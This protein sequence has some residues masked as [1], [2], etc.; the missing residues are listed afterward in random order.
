MNSR[1]KLVRTTVTTKSSMGVN[2]RSRFADKQGFILSPLPLL[3]L[4]HPPPSIEIKRR[5]DQKQ[6]QQQ[7]PPGRFCDQ[8][9][10]RAKQ[11]HQRRILLL[12]GCWRGGGRPR[13]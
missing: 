9:A 8:P 4:P 5:S 13:V 12:V 10:R 2:P 11:P 7:K 1:A 6:K 3:L